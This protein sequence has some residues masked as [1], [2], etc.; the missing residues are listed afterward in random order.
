MEERK[1]RKEKGT[2]FGI[3]RVFSQLNVA[4]LV[5]KILLV[6]SYVDVVLQNVFSARQ[7]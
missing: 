7:N 5:A 2:L 6:E 3:F 1:R 4:N